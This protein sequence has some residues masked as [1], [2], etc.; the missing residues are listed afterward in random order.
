MGKRERK[1]SNNYPN[2]TGQYRHIHSCLRDSEGRFI[3]PIFEN[4]DFKNQVVRY[5]L[6]DTK[7]Y[8]S[9]PDKTGRRTITLL[10]LQS[11]DVTIIDSNYTGPLFKYCT[12]QVNQLLLPIDE[13]T[14]NQTNPITKLKNG[15]CLQPFCKESK[16][17]YVNSKGNKKRTKDQLSEGSLGARVRSVL[18]K[19]CNVEQSSTYSIIFNKFNG[20]CFKCKKKLIF[21]ESGEKG[22][23]HTLPLS[24]WYPLTNQTATLLCKDCNSKKRAA[25]P[26]QF[27]TQQELIELSKMVDIPLDQLTNPNLSFN[28]QVVDYFLNNFDQVFEKLITTTR[29]S[30]E[31]QLVKITEFLKKE[32]LLLGKNP[33]DKINLLVN[34]LNE[35]LANH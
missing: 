19:N 9:K 33:T 34:K 4:N 11:F 7:D 14:T 32:T 13:F 8:E 23:D 2:F 10:Q 28:P 25:P 35:K 27:Y 26:T 1:H 31:R 20:T 30:K 15:L 18:L 22:L 12:H 17:L 29:R 6:L 24:L 5:E 16:K 3:R 21:E